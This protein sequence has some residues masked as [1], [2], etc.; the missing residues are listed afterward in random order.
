MVVIIAT[1][2]KG[3]EK[4]LSYQTMDVN[5][6]TSVNFVQKRGYLKRAASLGFSLSISIF[7]IP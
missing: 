5:I 4:K 3:G 7:S 6:K 2:S 1:D